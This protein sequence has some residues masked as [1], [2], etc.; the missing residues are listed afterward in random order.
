M[1]KSKGF[2]GLVGTAIFFFL[3]STRVSAANIGTVVP[4]LGQV[5]DLVHDAARNLVYLA[6]PSRNQVEIYSV[7]TGRLTGS[8]PTGLQP[9]SLAMSPDG[10][11]LYA[12]NVGSFTL[13]VISLNVQ[14]VDTD[15]FVGSR[16]DAIAVGNDGKIVLLGTAGLLRLDPATGQTQPVP[17]S[18]PAT[19]PAGLPVTPVSPTP[20][21]FLA[22]LVTAANGNLIIGLSTNRLFVYEVASGSVLRSRNVTGLRAILSASPDGS[23]FMAGPFLFDTRTMAILGRA[24]TVSPTLTGGSVFS[25]DGNDVYATF[26]TQ[27][28]INPLNTNNPQNTGAIVIPGTPTTTQGALQILRASSLTPELGLRLPEQITSKIISSSDGAMLF[29]NST[30]GMLVIPVGQLNNL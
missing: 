25:A 18:P 16:P 17:I 20:A 22:G 10:N 23:R 11:T 26:S 8:I 5:V 13:S 6:N 24:G 19:P 29:A 30:S 12:A 9:A 21:G 15:F 3:F 14:R 2:F 7:S 27:N 1:T 28:A 4:V